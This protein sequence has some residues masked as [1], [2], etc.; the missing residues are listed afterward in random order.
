[1]DFRDRDSYQPLFGEG[2]HD[3]TMRLGD[4]PGLGRVFGDLER[5]R[6]IEESNLPQHLGGVP[7]Y[8]SVKTE[9]ALRPEEVGVNETETA[10]IASHVKA[11]LDEHN[12][13]FGRVVHDPKFI[14]SLP[15]LGF[16]QLE[17]VYI[18]GVVAQS[19][20]HNLSDYTSRPNYKLGYGSDSQIESR[21]RENSGPYSVERLSNIAHHSY[22]QA[23]D[24]VFRL[25]INGLKDLMHL[26]KSK[27][28]LSPEREKVARFAKLQLEKLLGVQTEEVNANARGAENEPEPPPLD[29]NEILKL[30]GEQQRR[31]F[32]DWIDSLPYG[33]K[34]IPPIESLA[35]RQQ[36][37]GE[38]VS[39]IEYNIAPDRLRFLQEIIDACA[40]NSNVVSTEI[41]R[42]TLDDG[43][44]PIPYLALI[45]RLRRPGSDRIVETA[46]LERPEELQVKNGLSGEITHAEDDATYLFASDEED[47]WRYVFYHNVTKQIARDQYAMRKNHGPKH[48]ENVFKE[49]DD[50]LAGI[51]GKN[52][53]YN[54]YPYRNHQ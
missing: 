54:Q 5:K 2:E 12:I 33:G 26:P 21:A 15:H 42:T 8:E 16:N 39:S 13:D 32:F 35:A 50:M 29:I 25:C 19:L 31:A 11:V 53:R 49:L 28:M 45:I 44:S 14:H 17:R 18:L 20:E 43:P 22:E 23:D 10:Q 51:Q 40:E 24:H 7:I 3:D 36:S 6:R 27:E 37:R 48:A 9:Y 1:M 30:S 4:M 47:L 41:Y 46:I 38:R 34:D 52:N